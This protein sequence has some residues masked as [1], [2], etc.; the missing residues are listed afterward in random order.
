MNNVLT[1]AFTFSVPP[2]SEEFSFPQR[3]N[4]TKTFG[5][6]VI[7]DYGNDTVQINLSGSTINQEI[8]LIYKSSLGVSEMTGEQEIFYLRDLLKKYGTRDNLQNKEVYL[9]SLNG[10]GRNTSNNAKW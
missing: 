4:E 7:A 8:K 2:E 3:K 10:G 9:Y 5:G 6:A 1:D